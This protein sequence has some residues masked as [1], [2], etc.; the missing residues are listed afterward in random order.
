MR[1]LLI[2]D[3]D[4]V[5]S[6]LSDVL[7]RHGFAVRRADGFARAVEL[8]DD[9]IEVALLDLGLPDGDGFGLCRAI[10]AAG[11]VPII[12]TSA[13][14]DLRSRIHGLH[15]GADDYLVKPYAVTELIA[16]IHAVVRRGARSAAAGESG[17]AQ[18]TVRGLC[19]DP[20]RGSVSRDGATVALTRKEFGILE[21]LA[22]RPGLVV[23]R[24]QLLSQVWGSTW[25]GDQHTLDVHV[26][27]VRAKCRDRRVIETVRGIGYRLGGERRRD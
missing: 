25:M 9:E 24:E 18:V 19:I 27:A 21:A 15:V 26:A 11:D 4:R 12:I 14:A 23:R 13:R 22:R 6:A 5:A 2:E 16:R 10:R 17:P 8:L 1:L 3:D 20:G 7:G